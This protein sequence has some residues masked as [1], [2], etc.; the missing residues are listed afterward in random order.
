MR[1]LPAVGGHTELVQKFALYGPIE[2]WRMLDQTDG[3]AFTDVLWIK[4]RTVDEAKT[5]RKHLDDSLFYAHPLHVTYAPEYVFQ[6]ARKCFFFFGLKNRVDTSQKPK[7]GR[8][9]SSDGWQ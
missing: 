1:N 5:A 8:S 4:F 9:Y 2:E 7:R 6:L 3:D